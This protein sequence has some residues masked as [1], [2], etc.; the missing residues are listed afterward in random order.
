MA[1]KRANGEG[2]FRKR[3][4][5]SWEGRIM[6]DGDTRTVRGKS[7]SEVKDKMLEL[8]NDIYNDTLIQ[9]NEIT[10]AE[11]MNTWIDCYTAKTKTSTRERYRQDIRCHIVPELGAFRVQELRMPSVQKFLNRCKDV[12][13]LSEKSVKNIYL[14][15]NKAMATAQK[16]GIIKTNPCAD[17]EIPSYEDPHKEMR[18]LKDGEVSHFLEL[19]KGNPFEHLFFVDMFTGMRQSE[20]IGLTWDCVDWDKSEIH[21]YR[22]FK[23]VRGQ[24]KTYTFTNLKNK[25]DRTFT[26]APSVMQA[27]K[28]VKL[29][30]AEWKLHYGNVFQNKDGFV[31]TDE[32]G[33]HLATRTV[34]NRFKDIV[35]KMGL[36]EVRFHDLRH[37]YATL[38][39]QNGVDVKTVSYNLGHSTVAFTMDKYMHVTM[40]MQKDSVQKMESF[41]ASL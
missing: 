10:V 27:L 35:E 17:T 5:N 28:S 18:P 31:F 34:Y 32:L 2:S 14:V 36:P 16:T 29:Q 25:Q 38:A 6:V 22:Q 4:A 24:T 23:A 30:Q 7:R 1:K 37:T 11:W 41:I 3:S 20:I 33:K 9:E 26:V 8:Q 21:L 19:I 39:L 12:N 40:N 13:G 15:L